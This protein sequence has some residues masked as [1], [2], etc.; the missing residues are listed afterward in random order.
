MYD[1]KR[2]LGETADA[3][4][5]NHNTAG[6]QRMPELIEALTGR[7]GRLNEQEQEN[8][9]VIM[10]NLLEAYENKEYVMTADILN[11]DVVQILN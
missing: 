2:E 9:I 6:I 7:I 4:Y 1:I 3:F 8:C 5:Q 10:K 11:Y